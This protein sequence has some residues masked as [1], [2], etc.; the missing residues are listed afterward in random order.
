MRNIPETK[1][2]SLMDYVKAFLRLILAIIVVETP[3]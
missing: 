3:P 2:E 1:I